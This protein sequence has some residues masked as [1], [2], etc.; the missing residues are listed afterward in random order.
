MKQK[1]RIALF[2]MLAVALILAACDGDSGN[3]GTELEGN[4]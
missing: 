1:Q 3:N 2:G 4:S